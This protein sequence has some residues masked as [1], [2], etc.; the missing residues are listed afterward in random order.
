MFKKPQLII[1]YVL[2]SLVFAGS[3]AIAFLSSE[4]IVVCLG[5]GVAVLSFISGLITTKS[6]FD[7]N[8]LA[9]RGVYIDPNGDYD[10]IS[11]SEDDYVNTVHITHHT[12]K[13]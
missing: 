4:V 10:E 7:L 9:E 13:D 2:P 5:V 8:K 1:S 3:V 12:G 6:I 11:F